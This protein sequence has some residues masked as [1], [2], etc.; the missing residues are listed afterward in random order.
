M[1]INDIPTSLRVPAQVPLDA[2]AYVVSKE[3]L[4]DLGVNSYKAYTYYNGMRVLCASERETYE[5]KEVE[6]TDIK[7]LV[8]DFT[9][10]LGV[11]AGGIDYSNKTYNFALVVKSD[12]NNI[13][14]YIEVDGAEIAE[15]LPPSPEQVI[16]YLNGID[17]TNRLNIDEHSIYKIGITYSIVGEF[18]DPTFLPRALWNS[19]YVAIFDLVNIG[20]GILP[21]LTESNVIL[22]YYQEINKSIIYNQNNIVRNIFINQAD[23]PP[24]YSTS[25]LITAILALPPEQRTI[26]ETTSKVNILVG[27]LAS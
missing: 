6:P 9:Y 11:I 24:D 21:N 15:H 16:G 23:L 8:S 17:P 18:E 7:L 5:W 22:S 27:Y 20:K 26:E 3:D 14:R 1:N 13:V 12:E 10:P 2:K 4:R 19:K 25:D